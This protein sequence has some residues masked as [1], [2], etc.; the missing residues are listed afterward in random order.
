MNMRGTKILH[1]QTKN[2]LCWITLE[3]FYGFLIEFVL[4]TEEAGSVANITEYLFSK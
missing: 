3:K 4:V 1:Y 2:K